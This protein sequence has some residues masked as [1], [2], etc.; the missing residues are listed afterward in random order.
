MRCRRAGQLPGLEV[1]IADPDD[2]WQDMRVK[3]EVSYHVL[4]HP[5]RL[6]VIVVFPRE[7]VGDLFR[8]IMAPEQE[9]ILRRVPSSVLELVYRTETRRLAGQVKQL[10][11][12]Q[13]GLWELG[14]GRSV[15]LAA[16]LTDGGPSEQLDVVQSSEAVQL[17]IMDTEITMSCAFASPTRYH[18]LLALLL[19]PSAAMTICYGVRSDAMSVEN[20][21]P[22]MGFETDLHRR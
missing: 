13:E 15:D 10:P 2:L 9:R 16:T 3:A 12:V 6:G 11:V 14:S 1:T 7:Q 17:S 22:D 18:V 20:R 21:L 4:S 19:E 5:S 8:P